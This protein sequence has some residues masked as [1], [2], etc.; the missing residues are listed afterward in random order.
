[1][2]G[3]VVHVYLTGT[4]AVTVAPLA[5]GTLVA[6]QILSEPGGRPMAQIIG[7]VG[8]MWALVTALSQALAD[9]TG[10]P[11]TA[12]HPVTIVVEPLNSEGP[13]DQ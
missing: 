10:Q 2:S 6:G 5:D 1:M 4:Q 11:S 8:E 7:P 9:F 12:V 13:P 3:L